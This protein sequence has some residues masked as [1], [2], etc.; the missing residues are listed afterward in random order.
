MA[1]KSKISSIKTKET[2]R[3]APSI[4]A[5]NKSL[6]VGNVRTGLDGNKWKVIITKTGIRKWTK[7]TT[8]SKT[9]PKQV[10]VPKLGEKVRT[11]IENAEKKNMLVNL[12]KLPNKYVLKMKN[13]NK[14]TN[15][16]L[17]LHPQGYT[18]L[19]PSMNKNNYYNFGGNAVLGGGAHE[20]IKILPGL[21]KNIKFF[22]YK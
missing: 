18:Y 12:N 8:T 14:M 16:N 10:D 9:T 4:S 6:N 22:K 19:G 11:M 2:S 5:T 3:K 17:V 20:S 13:L 21:N 7:V 1:N 15:K